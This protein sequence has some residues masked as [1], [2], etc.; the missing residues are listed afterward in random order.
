MLEMNIIIKSRLIN[1]MP[2]VNV[3]AD[4]LGDIDSIVSAETAEKRCNIQSGFTLMELMVVIVI[5][6]VLAG[7]VV[8]RIMDE[9]HKARV[10]KAR[11]QMEQFAMALETFKMDNGYYP[12]SQ[13]GLAALVR[14]PA[15]GREA[16][17]YRIGGYLNKIPSDPW[18]SEYAYFSPSSHGPY[19]I[20]SYG[21]D[22][23]QG[24]KNEDADINNWETE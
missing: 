5:L 23:Q 17:N 1:S 14:A 15:S 16:R 10:V 18:G 4:E 7:L 19:A 24:G 2:V 11:L 13:Q 20:V 6:G 3:K 8:P 22:A 12:D 9:P 21:A